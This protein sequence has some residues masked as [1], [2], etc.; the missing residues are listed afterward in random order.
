[1]HSGFERVTC[2]KLVC[3][4]DATNN[5]YNFFSLETEGAF[6]KQCIL[7]PDLSHQGPHSFS[8][9]NKTLI[10][11]LIYSTRNFIHDEHPWVVTWSLSV[12]L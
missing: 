9:Y 11:E 2:T 5:Y 7:R 10:K 8:K 1:M 12:P 3:Y 6:S 4:S